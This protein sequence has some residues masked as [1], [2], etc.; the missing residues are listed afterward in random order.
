MEGISDEMWIGH[1]G[2]HLGHTGPVVSPRPA[3][4]TILRSIRDGERWLD[5]LLDSV[6]QQSHT[7]WTLLARDDGSTDQGVEIVARHGA[8]DERVVVVDDDLGSLGPAGSFMSLLARVDHGYFAFC[9]A[10]CVSHG[11]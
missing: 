2:E 10:A 11:T 4:V 7:A 6:R 3:H 9:D 1:L 5:P 8:D